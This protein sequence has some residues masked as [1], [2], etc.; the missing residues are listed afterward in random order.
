MELKAATIIFLICLGVLAQACSTH[1]QNKA[2]VYLYPDDD[3]HVT[4]IDCTTFYVDSMVILCTKENGE[5][6][7]W[8]WESEKVALV[9]NNTRP[10]K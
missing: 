1:L 5:K 10:F 8:L 6:M 4:V 7:R 2:R 3:G 9:G